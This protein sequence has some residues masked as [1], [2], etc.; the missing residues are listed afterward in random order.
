MT[1]KFKLILLLVASVVLSLSLAGIFL[2]YFFIELHSQNAREDINDAFITL[3]R[4]LKTS[5]DFLT[6]HIHQTLQRDDIRSAVNMISEYQ[7]IDDYMPILFDV[8]KKKIAVEIAQQARS[9]RVSLTTVYDANRTLIAFIVKESKG[10]RL[11]IVSYEKGKPVIYVSGIE[12]WDSWEQAPLP[13]PIAATLAVDAPQSGAVHYKAADWDFSIEISQPFI[14]RFPDGSEKTVGFLRM[15]HFMGADFATELA[16]KTN[17]N[18]QIFVNGG[19]GSGTLGHLPFSESI[20]QASSLF[21]PKQPRDIGW[22]EDEDHFLH[23]HFVPLEGGAKAYFV[24]GTEKTLLEAAIKRTLLV[25]TA[26]LLLSALIVTLAGIYIANLVITR[27]VAGLVQAVHAF[28]EGHYDGNITA[29]THDEL[30][31]LNRSFGDMASTIQQREL[32]LRNSEKHLAKTNIALEVYRD[33]LEELVEERT[34]ELAVAKDSAE[35]ASRAKSVFLANMSHE[36]RTPLNAVLG[37]SQ[38]MQDDPQSTSSQLEKLDIINRSGNHL[39]TLINDV[40]DMTKIEA[41]RTLLEASPFDLGELVLDLI[42]MMR[43]RAEEKGLQLL[44]DQSSQFPRFIDGDAPKLRQIL[45]NLLSNAVKFT[46]QGGVTLRLASQPGSDAEHIELRCE[47]ED[48]GPGIAAAELERIFKP[49][50]QLDEQGDQEGTGLGLTITRQYVELMGGRINAESEPGKGALFR[51]SLPVRKALESDITALSPASEQVAGLAPNQPAYRILIAE[52]QPDNQLLL[53]TLLENVGLTT[54][55]AENGKQAVE[56]FEQWRPQLIFMD[57]RMPVM[58]GMEATKLIRALPHGKEPSIVALTASA[59]T[60]ERDEIMA[61]GHDAFISKPFRT[62]EIFGCLQRLLGIKFIYTEGAEPTKTDELP[63]AA[64]QVSAGQLRTL[65]PA[66]FEALQRAVL[67][68]DVERSKTLIGE[69]TEEDP[70]LAAGL[71]HYVDALDFRTL[72]HLL[73]HPVKSGSA[74]ADTVTDH[75]DQ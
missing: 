57:W 65:A 64:P 27:P 12:D 13:L 37:F 25:L 51:F 19:S 41:G 39:L 4:E 11:G 56:L 49:F 66:L 8:E 16:A 68:L 9:P 26:V 33:H 42:D 55:V 60:D 32:E 6:K 18:V 28:K 5:E 54:R 17:M 50:I 20:R 72:Q 43:V 48:S 53:K 58:D 31:L 34:T 24:L 74:T 47:V 15:V 30:G 21:S 35:T 70:S 52:D 61:S 14:R 38:L 73:E 1:I 44:L 46:A 3:E 10:L 59:F 36:L 75:P 63:E 62:E 69:I 71:L 40:L 2:F 29:K 23:A 45:I 7:S 22:L 67:E